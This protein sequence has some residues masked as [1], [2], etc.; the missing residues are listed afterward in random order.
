M[1][2]NTTRHTAVAAGRR[3]AALA[4]GLAVA[5]A[6]AAAWP[7]AARADNSR[8]E[9]TKALVD[10]VPRDGTGWSN[11]PAALVPRGGG[12]YRLEYGNAPAG[13]GGAALPGVPMI[14]DNADGNPVVERR[15]AH[16]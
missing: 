2:G 9:G 8:G 15:P 5:A 16:R 3:S 1:S 4:L 7:G 14:I 13:D 11:G 10:T 6:A 12:K